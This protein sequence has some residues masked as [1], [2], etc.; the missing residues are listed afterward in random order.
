MAMVEPAVTGENGLE[1]YINNGVPKAA[2]PK[3]R[4]IASNDAD[5]GVATFCISEE[6]HTLGNALRYIVMKNPAVT[7]CGY[8]LPHPSEYMVNFRIQTDGTISAVDALHKGLD[9]LCD[10]CEH[11]KTTFHQKVEESGLDANGD[12][13]ME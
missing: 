4:I 8:S 3:I 12:V 9:D 1:T 6:D 13:E 10:L 7:F 2:G 5:P 11:V